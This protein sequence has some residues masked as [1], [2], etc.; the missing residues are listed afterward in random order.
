MRLGAAI[1]CHVSRVGAR[2]GNGRE[3]RRAGTLCRVS[4]PD[5]ERVRRAIVDWYG[6]S[7]RDLPWRGAGASAWGVLVSEFMLQ[8]TPVVRVLP[9]WTEWMRRW[10]TPADLAEESRAEVL[11]AWG[12]LGYPRRALRL[13][14]SA[15][16]IV[17]SFGGEVPRTYEELLSLPGV[18]T[19]TAAAVASFAFGEREVVVDTNI[20]RVEARLVSGVAQPAASLTRAET[21]VAARLVPEQD[22]FGADSAAR[23]NIAVMELGAL[24]CT[25]RS[26]KCVEC[27]VVGDCAWVDAGRPAPPIDRPRRTQAWHGTDRQVRG[28]VMAVLRAAGGGGS[29]AVGSAGVAADV[30]ELESAG[31]VAADRGVGGVARAR[32]GVAPTVVDV[33]Y[34]PLAKLYALGASEEQLERAVSGLVADGLAEMDESKAVLRLPS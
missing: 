27:P 24:V 6:R 23:W 34:E 8:Q 1:F 15:A 7:A 10:P 29:A 3:P 32:L 28:A 4:S 25:A 5:I 12:R 20:R 33:V 9:V 22:G 16:A 11:R 21:E 14:A 26:P 13:H 18:G 17:E 31:E 19:Y 2:G 30:A